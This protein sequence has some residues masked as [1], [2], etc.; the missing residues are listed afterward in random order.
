[1]NIMTIKSRFIIAGIGNFIDAI[2]T[3][4]LTQFYGFLEVN[5]IMAWLLQYPLLTVF[6]KITVVSS[7]LVY[8]YRQEHNKYTSILATFAACL[9]GAI[10]IYY[11]VFFIILL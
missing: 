8:A 2:A 7:V 5:P 9:Y 11:I 6:L 1:M 10:A 4:I 3:F